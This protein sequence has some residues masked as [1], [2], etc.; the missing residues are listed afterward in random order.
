MKK[1]WR[2]GDGGKYIETKERRPSNIQHRMLNRK[3]EEAEDLIRFSLRE[4][5]WQKRD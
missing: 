3:D 1:I 2:V 4:S 5:N